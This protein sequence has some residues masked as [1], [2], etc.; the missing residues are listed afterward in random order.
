MPKSKGSRLDAEARRQGY[1]SYAAMVAYQEK[2]QKP[3]TRTVKS[4]PKRNFLQTL[5]GSIP[6]P[7][8]YA[9]DRMRRAVRGRKKK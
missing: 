6:N 7:M 8:N 1:P 5:I 9:A 3:I 2:Y 4:A